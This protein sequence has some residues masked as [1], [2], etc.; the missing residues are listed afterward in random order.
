MSTG[1]EAVVR[2]DLGVEGTAPENHSF[3]TESS[4]G[5]PGGVIWATGADVVERAASECRG[6]DHRS[7]RSNLRCPRGGSLTTRLLKSRGIELSRE[8]VSEGYGVAEKGLV[9]NAP[10]SFTRQDTEA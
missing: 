3:Y 2:F 8:V 5:E 6:G 10:Y 4:A 1:A 9:V 7:T